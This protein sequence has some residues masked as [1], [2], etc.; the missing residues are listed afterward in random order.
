[1]VNITRIENE[2]KEDNRNWQLY[3][4]DDIVI[5]IHTIL[6]QINKINNNYILKLNYNLPINQIFY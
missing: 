4:D 6:F 5:I 3:D 2:R 1:M